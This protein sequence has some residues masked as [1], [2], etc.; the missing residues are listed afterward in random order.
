MRKELIKLHRAE[1]RRRR[2]RGTLR[3]TPERPRLA[4][5][6]FNQ[7]IYAQII[8]DVAGRTLVAVHS[9]GKELRHARL[10]RQREGGDGG[11][12]AAG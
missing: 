1:L 5:S 2:V 8:D 9:A 10:R 11:R 3:G 7:N 12:Q 4:V 6:R